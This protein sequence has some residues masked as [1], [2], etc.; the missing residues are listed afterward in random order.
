MGA[1]NPLFLVAAAAAAVPVFLHLFQRQESRRIAFPALRY[2]ERTE[3]E[4]ARRIRFRQL[5]L[6]LL[7]VAAVLAV[8]GA[9]ARLFLGG[10]GAAHPPTAVAIVLDNS[11][12]TGLVVGEERVLDHLK[13]LALGTLQAAFEDDVIWV[14][15]AGEPW[16]PAVPGGPEAARGVVEE[17]TVSAAAGDLSA[18]LARASELVSTSGLEA[19]EIHLLSDLQASAFHERG[20]APAGDAPVIVWAPAES[21]T[22]NRAL[23][24]VVVGGGLP[25]LEGQ[26]SDVT[27]T[28]SAGGPD[29]TVAVPVRLVLGGRVR[30]AGAVPPGASLTLP[31]PPA[32]A[33]W[34]LGYADADPDA[35]RADD[36]RFFTFQARPAPGVA[37]AGEVG[38]FLAEAVAVLESGGRL[39]RDEVR[40]ADV[41]MSGSGEGLAGVGAGGSVLIL[42][43]EDPTLL[44]ALNR[45]LQEGGIPWRV[46]R[47]DG[48]GEAALEGTAL[49][50]PLQ[51][52][53][54][55]LW[56]RLS[57]TSDPSTPTRTLALATGDP[58]AV[59][60]TDPAGRR[61][62]LLA[63]PLDATSTSLPVSADMIR[64]VDWLTAEWAATGGG[65]V[66]RT[67]GDPLSAPREA[68]ALRLPSGVE[69]PLDGTRQFSGTGEA[70]IY[71]FLV[72]D[73]AVA[74][75]ALNPSAAES[76]LTLLGSDLLEWAV[77]PEVTQ[78]RRDAAWE[79]A[80]FR[81]RQG[82]ELWRPLML[83]TLVLLVLEAGVAATGP[84]A[85][86]RRK[87][88][89]AGAVRGAS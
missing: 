52:T 27:V 74:Y 65:S 71:A 39:R 56:Y 89:P 73:S 47:S 51:A 84:L 64:F 55:R 30:G 45:R 42:P 18:A 72:G 24:A 2:L 48:E 43:P 50:A 63:S 46:E 17:T 16:L 53:R 9:G 4:H 5:L 62:L 1:L 22:P 79:G 32:P 85:G 33:G 66:E 3:R 26:R 31:L 60:G 68:D 61:Y 14:I 6:L 44:P 83:A 87:K 19:R 37:L 59:E 8:V 34:V 76:D 82:P 81:S 75:V 23:T 57:L 58:W 20:G 36:R 67:A 35:L 38:V 11:M 21:P 77:G 86:V 10:A 70:G 12:S 29:D 49:P 54:A 13:G 80:I 78:V 40:R 15:R 88:E 69:L 28:A 41:V 25:P 7:R